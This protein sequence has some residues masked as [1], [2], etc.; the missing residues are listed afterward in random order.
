MAALSLRAASRSWLSPR[1]LGGTVVLALLAYVPALTSSPGRMAADTKLYLYLDPGR[2]VADSLWTFDAR[3]FAGWVPHQ[4][5]AYLWPSGPWYVV[6]QA[7]GLPDWVAHR[8]WIGTIIFAAGAG[9][10]WAARRRLGLS[11]AAAI[12]AGLIYQCSPYLV[13]YI[14][15]TSSMLLP[16]AGLGWIVGLTVGAATRTRWRDAALC[17]LVVATVGNVNATALVMIAPA[18]VMWLAVAVAERTITV[19]RAVGAAARIG[20]LILATAAWWIVMLAIQGREGADLLDFSESLEDVS[21]TA[22]SVE[23]W[24]SLGY[25][26]MYVRDAYAPTTTAGADYMSSGRP[27]YFGFAIVAV[28]LAGFAA[29]RFAARRFAIVM[30][31]AGVVLAVGVHPFEDP[32]PAA[33]LLTNDGRSGLALALRSSTRALPLLTL[34][35]G[36]GAGALVD[37]LAAATPRKAW[38]RALR[39]GAAA[40]VGLLAVG[41]LP[42]LTGHRLVDPALE[43]EQF[44]PQGWYD[45]AAALDELPDGYRV[46]QLPGQEFGAF[47]WGY[48]VDP[49]LPGLIER[50]LV[51]RDLLPLGSPAAMDLLYALDD[52]FQTARPELEAV[53]PLARL[54]GADVIWLTGDAA[55]ERF[56]TPR[57]EVTSNLFAGADDDAGLDLGDPV[58]YGIPLPNL[59]DVPMVDEQALSHPDIGRPVAPVELVA[60]EDPL[61]V[62]RASAEELLVSGSGDGLVDAAAAG[63]LGGDEA[64]RYSAA[65]RGDELAAAAD[66]ADIVIVTDSNRRRAHH[67]RSSQ[68]VTGYTEGVGGSALIWPD[69]GDARLAVF[70]DAPVAAFTTSRSDG[71]VSARATSYG[72]RFSYQPESRPALAI[73]GDPNT[74]WRVLDPAFQYLELSTD[75]GVDHVTLLQPGGPESGRHAITALISVNGGRR[76]EVVLDERSRLAGQRIELPPTDGPTTVRIELGRLNP[77]PASGLPDRTPVGFAEADLG[78]GPSPEVISV[79]TDLTAAMRAAGVA[80]PVTYVLTRD[81]VGAVGRWRSD[82]E[83][84]IVRDVEV[85]FDQAASVTVDVRLDRRAADTALAA[86]LDIEGPTASSRLTGVPAAGGWAAADGDPSTAWRSAFGEA[87]GATLQVE[88]VDPAAPLTVHQPGGNYTTITALRVT[89]GDRNAELPVPPPEAGEVASVVPLPAGFTRGRARI[90]IAAVDSHTTRDRRFADPMQMPAAIVELGN[91]AAAELPDSFATDCRDDLVAVDGTPIPVRV[92]GTVAAAFAGEALTAT[93]CEQEALELTAGT[94]RVTGQ[95]TRLSGLQTDRIVVDGGQR[96]DASATDPIATV[97]GS[98]RL[99]RTVQLDRC[100]E[101]CWLILGEGHHDAWQ[102][103][104]GGR[105][106]GP[107]ELISG[108]FNGWWIPAA[109]VTDGTA[110]V[111][112]AWTAQGPLNAALV[113]SGIGG[114]VAIV[115]LARERR[116]LPAVALAPARLRLLGPSDGLRR[117]AIAAAV[118]VAAAAAF[119]TPRY[120]LWGLLGA[121]LVVVT[122]RARIAVYVALGALAYIAAKVVRFVHAHDPPPTPSF[123]GHFTALHHL[124]L[125]AAVSVL[126]GALARRGRSA[127]VAPASS[128]TGA[129]RGEFGQQ[130]SGRPGSAHAGAMNTDVG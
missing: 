125:F 19:R 102:A 1:R 21:L 120:A 18:P 69:P 53:A 42:A 99:G 81:R 130:A 59:A 111:E 107:P 26:L 65:L 68:D 25:W 22:T 58:A 70:P 23:V 2:L 113:V 71:P 34:G 93:V 4:V 129:G 74:A 79:P 37:A 89:Q 50:P 45:A 105:S 47:R 124:G 62:I 126:V 9:V 118:Y 46:L 33:A 77:P 100:D 39:Y 121:G 75:E 7:L 78:L 80:R 110:T 84:T 48:T 119:V 17:A 3:Q 13:P 98:S 54:L 91:V 101:G 55:F 127:P 109:A 60:V 104:S 115:L 8:L 28:G 86:L 92:D 27:L 30:V 73:D 117:A 16:W 6:A 96:T 24:R 29:T 32:S 57:P 114:L 87:L 14:S 20:A 85:P 38:S 43:R 10:S 90:E 49:P 5:I 88:L 95:R 72:E 128:T 123:P 31:F 67:W 61:P 44:P 15:R 116:S 36:L 40:A 41:N 76:F 64:I 11:L 94:H 35:L 112:L 82:P 108:G 52:R 66:A 97:T 63:L 103:R 51:T 122:R 12:A 83:W 106:L 56:R